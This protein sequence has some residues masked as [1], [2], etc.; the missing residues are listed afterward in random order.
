MWVDHWLFTQGATVYSGHS[1]PYRNGKHFAGEGGEGIEGGGVGRG[2]SV[3]HS[4]APYP[5]M[6]DYKVLP[7][8]QKVRRDVS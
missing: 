2:N 6:R 4:P 3:A 1:S 5:P 8:S 7:Q